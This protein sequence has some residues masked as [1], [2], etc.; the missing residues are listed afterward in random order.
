[1]SL[2]LMEAELV[3]GRVLAEVSVRVRPRP[4]EDLE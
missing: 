3:K 1:M 4:D 2:I